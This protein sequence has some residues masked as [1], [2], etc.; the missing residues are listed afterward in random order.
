MQ[1]SLFVSS[2]GWVPAENYETAME[3][4]K[5]LFRQ[6]L[7]MLSK[8]EDT[9][10]DDPLKDEEDVRAIWLYDVWYFTSLLF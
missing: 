1:D 8:G 6:F 4:Q 10:P 9:D 2:D 5:D 3:M 7:D